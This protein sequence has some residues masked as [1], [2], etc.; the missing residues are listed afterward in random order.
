MFLL[1]ADVYHYNALSDGIKR[2]YTNDDELTE[3][4]NR[5]IL[6][7]NEVSYYNL[8]I[9]GVLQPKVNYEIEKGKLTL[10]T[11]DVPLKDST[12][13]I[14]FITFR[15][16][17]SAKLNSAKVEGIIPSGHIYNGPVTDMDINIRNNI[18][19]FLKLEKTLVSGPNSIPLGNM[20]NWQF[21]IKIK[22]ISSS[23]INNI[24]VTDEV[25]LDSV[26][27]I[28]NLL[29]SKGD[30]SIEGKLV[31][32]N[33]DF[34]DVDESATVDI[35][36]SG[37]F[38][39]DGLRFLSR[40]L[41]TGNSSLGTITSDIV[42]GSEIVVS[43]GLDITKVITSGPT[44]VNIGEINTW[45][46][47]IKATNLSDEDLFDLLIK[48]TLLIDNIIDIKIV[49]I[50]SGNV[51]FIDNEIHW[52]IDVL[53]K[54]ESSILVIDVIGSFSNEGYRSL[55]TGAPQDF[56]IIVYSNNLPIVEKL[57]LEKSIL[58]EPL[59][60]LSG[61]PKN[62]IFSIKISNHSRD[63]LRNITVIDYILLDDLN[64]I[65]I[66]SIT[67]GDVSI[68][69]S[70]IIWTIEE[71][72]PKRSLTAIFEVKGSF[73][74][75]GL[76]ALNRAIATA[77]SSKS[78]LISNISSGPSIRVMDKNDLH[79]S[80]V[81]V[82]K[83]FSQCK[84]KHCL[85]EVNVEIGEDSFKDI[86]F[87]PGFI[88]KNTLKIIDYENNL[89]RV[90]FTLKV[91]FEIKATKNKI[92]KGYLPDIEKDILMPFPKARDEFIFNILVETS[93]KLL[94]ETVKNDNCLSFSVGMFIIIKVVGKVN[95]L[96]PSYE[97]VP[98]PNC[99]KICDRSIYDIFNSQEPDLYPLQRNVFVQNK[100]AHLDKCN[101]CPDIFGNLIIEKYIVSGPIEVYPNENNRWVVEIRAT[102]SGFGPISNAK[103][104]DT[105]LLDNL[106]D[107]NIISISQGSISH[108]DNQISWDIGTLYSNKTA[109]ILAEVIGSFNFESNVLNV[110]N[111]QYNTISDGI[112]YE[113]TNDDEISEYGNR[114]IPDPEEV[115]FLNLYINGVLQPKTNYLVEEG[116][117]TLTTDSLPLK[118]VPI[119]LEYI[120][121]KDSNNQ[122]IKAETYQY[123]T[124]SNGGKVYTNEDE[125][126][127]YGNNGI[128]DPQQASYYNLFI[129]GVIQPRVSYTVNTGI[130]RL[131]TED[132]PIIGAPIILQF[133]SLYV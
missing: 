120:I 117:L 38:K 14:T 110:E 64:E 119:I 127:E 85:N 45:R 106:I 4:G 87:K 15:D 62:W 118:G 63:I 125:I 130:L 19:S 131:E 39:T 96:I 90:R 107:F 101:L 73:Q 70:S 95:I 40:G 53:E 9:N 82:N 88:L 129:N 98:G 47:E 55:Y 114:G 5:G 18:Y 113:Y 92:I 36:I 49:S 74:A 100:N 20:A 75:A 116:L 78:C 13:I 29:P 43:K 22:N 35:Q 111:Y 42:S 102:N 31:T 84:Q 91:P 71:L 30:V 11:E 69:N 25:L 124:R 12:I 72:L 115:S 41:A 26:L 122:V 56:L 79:I 99:E 108:K 46:I 93:T 123:N 51:N 126:T 28:E 2:I 54:L 76:R 37:S 8:F 10:K 1:N 121:I 24:I 67:A 132:S 104:T 52:E 7:P 103:I 50:S 68:S 77:L 58:N 80:P 3:Y 61:S 128:L 48:D 97:F 32:W 94:G 83:V 33:V 89:K 57:S 109:I 27:N 81:M 17:E 112:K 86:V 105:L 44:K 65:K 16:L 34:L 6:D 23:P 60:S 66:K 133:I 21:T 59:A